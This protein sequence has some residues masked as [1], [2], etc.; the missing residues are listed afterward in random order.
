MFGL[1]E[2]HYNIVKRVA[3]ELAQDIKDTIKRDKTTYD[4][5]AAQ[6]IDKH[7]EKVSTLLARGQL[8]WLVGYLNNRFGKSDGEYE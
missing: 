2:P 8:I 4:R 3:K 6:I 1:S 7:Y 5:C